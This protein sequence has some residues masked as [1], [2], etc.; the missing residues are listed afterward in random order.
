M[1]SNAPSA[2]NFHIAWLCGWFPMR[3]DTAH[4]AAS[5]GAGPF[6]GVGVVH[7]ARAQRQHPGHLWPVRHQ[8]QEN[9]TGEGVVA[10]M[11]RREL[12]RQVKGV[13][14]AGQAVEQ[15]PSG[16]DGVFGREPFPGSHT[17]KT[18]QNRHG[19]GTSCGPQVDVESSKL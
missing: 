13:G 19:F 6:T 17:E 4:S 10:R 3:A 9:L 1:Q 16:G 15:D 5:H 18:G 11:Q 14:V 2:S 8:V 7:E 12:T